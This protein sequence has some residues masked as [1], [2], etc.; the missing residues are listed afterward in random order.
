M[1]SKPAP[2]G[3]WV[4]DG[5]VTPDGGRV[6]DSEVTLAT[7][8]Y[9][10]AIFLGPVIPL[11]VYALQARRSPFLRYHAATAVNLSISGALYALCCLILG[12]VLLLDSIA[13]ALAVV[14]PVGF[15]LW[16][17][18]LRYLIRGVS[19]ATRGERN[20]VPSWICARILR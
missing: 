12:G 15:A 8:G 9:L 17:S 14:V 5:E 10:G 6:R 16:V 2:D 18:V 20:A 1:T 11:I 4:R 3:G 7:F 13:V 19:A